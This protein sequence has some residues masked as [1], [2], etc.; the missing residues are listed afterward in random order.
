MYH[1]TIEAFLETIRCKKLEGKVQLVFTSPPFPLNH[2][3]KYGNRKGVEYLEW[4][5]SLAPRL[6]KLLTPDGSIVIEIGNSW[7]PGRPV[8][9][10]LALRSMLA[11]LERGRLNLCQEFIC[12]NPARLPSPIQWVNIER[13]R[14][15]DS[16]TH[17]WWMAP[18]DR[19]KADNRQVLQAYSASMNKLLERK[20]YNAGK[21]PSG[22][23]I[24]QLSFLE[25]NNGAIPPSVLFEVQNLLIYSNTGASEPYM[26]FCRA[27]QLELHP[28]RMQSKLA[29]FFVRFLTSPKDIVFD[30]FGG[31]NTTGAVAESLRRRWV[32]VEANEEYIQGSV[33]RFPVMAAN[34]RLPGPMTARR[35][36]PGKG[37]K[38]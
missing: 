34:A 13:V 14:V 29:D 32:T 35:H 30:P 7:E 24:G 37:R 12:H 16:Y 33:G 1:G 11:F 20:R 8:M 10:T 19:P 31:S 26:N 9:S 21:R 28:A 23:G 5:A 27:N 6:R 38:R 3:K 25:N 17:V 2:K 15:K 36:K 22:Y 4:L 18:S